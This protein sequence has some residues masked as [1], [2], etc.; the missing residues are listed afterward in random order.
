MASN[1]AV[2]DNK[3]PICMPTFVH[4]IISTYNICTWQLQH[5]YGYTKDTLLKIDKLSFTCHLTTSVLNA[6]TTG[7]D[8]LT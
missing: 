2:A 5:G 8:L 4:K 6:Q 7:N 3:Q 1:S